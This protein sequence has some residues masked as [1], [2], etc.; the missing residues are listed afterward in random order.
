MIQVQRAIRIPV[1]A[2]VAWDI[3]GDFSVQELMA[4]IC[5]RVTVEGTGVGAVRTLY[6]EPRFGAGVVRERLESLDLAN[7]HMTYRIVDSGPVPFA[8]YIGSVRV[9]PAGPDA[10]VAV[11]TSSFVPVEIDAEAARAL[12]VGN[13]EGA[14]ENA[15]QA[16]IRRLS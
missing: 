16:A 14:L 2:D 8:D 3:L 4:G 12:S 13:I 11:M 1:P 5:T 15:R 10:C 6:I 9:T 7:R